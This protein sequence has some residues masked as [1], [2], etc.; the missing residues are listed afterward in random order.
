MNRIAELILEGDTE[1][2]VKIGIRAGPICKIFE[3]ETAVIKEQFS[4]LHSLVCI[5]EKGNPE[6]Y[7]FPTNYLR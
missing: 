4:S 5:R 7:W 1:A 3:A 6:C 2:A